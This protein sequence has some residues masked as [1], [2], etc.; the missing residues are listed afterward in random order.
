[1]QEQALLRLSLADGDRCSWEP[2]RPV[3]DPAQ[4]SPVACFHRPSGSHTTQGIFKKGG[5]VVLGSRSWIIALLAGE[6]RE[7]ESREDACL[8]PG[9]LTDKA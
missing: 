7:K 9:H 8:L 4:L 3:E 5:W 1:M 6:E 2:R